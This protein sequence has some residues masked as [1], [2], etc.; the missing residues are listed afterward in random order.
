MTLS[1][2][3]G[4]RLPWLC[5]VAD[6]LRFDQLIVVRRHEPGLTFSV[7]NRRLLRRVL[8]S[9]ANAREIVERL[10]AAAGS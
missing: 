4:L 7:R 5:Y 1:M 8:L 3:V 6:S 10:G 9:A 2:K